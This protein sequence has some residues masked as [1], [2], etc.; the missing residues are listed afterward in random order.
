MGLRLW[1][2]EHKFTQTLDIK[3]KA[4]L[5]KW[6]KNQRNRKIRQIKQT[7]KPNIKYGGW[8]Y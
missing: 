3:G 4:G 6:L 7:E 8:E 5:R 2:I 1:Q